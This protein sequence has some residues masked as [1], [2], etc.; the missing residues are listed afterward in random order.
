MY[1]Y[2]R[3]PKNNRKISVTS[4]RGKY[5]LKKYLDFYHGGGDAEEQFNTAPE[6]QPERFYTALEE[7]PEEHPRNDDGETGRVHSNHDPYGP[8]PKNKADIYDLDP[9]N[10]DVQKY[11]DEKNLIVVKREGDL[12]CKNPFSHYNQ[13]KNCIEDP[14]KKPFS[15]CIDKTDL[16][17]YPKADLCGSRESMCKMY[18]YATQLHHPDTPDIEESLQ[19]CDEQCPLLVDYNNLDNNSIRIAVEKYLENTHAQWDG[20]PIGEWNTSE[21]TDMAYLFLRAES[22]NEPLNWDTGKVKIM[23]G[24]FWGA[25]SFN[26]PLDHWNTINVED[27]Q[28]MFSGATSFNQSLNWD[29]GNV[30]NMSY[31]FSGAI[32]F[33]QP[34]NF[35]NTSK[36][37]DM[38]YMFYGASRFNQRLDHWNTGNV[39]TMKS[40]FWGASSFDQFINWDLS[41]VRDIGKMFDR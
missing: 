36:V 21:V 38:S 23:K 20:R 5:I 17:H 8:P 12:N 39:F 6:E 9:D 37:E 2:I 40:M 29:T 15:F 18:H 10:P 33:N 14:Y 22:F 26:Q 24:M 41:R 28:G 16:I 4:N 31:M 32:S 35:T 7:Q 3:D 19:W 25:S 34:L 1:K 13:E 30:K 27:M 11:L